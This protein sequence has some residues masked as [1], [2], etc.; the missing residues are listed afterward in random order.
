MRA[1]FSRLKWKAKSRN[2]FFNLTFDEFRKLCL[3]SGYIEGV[4]RNADCLSLDRIDYQKGY[5]LSNLRVITISE[6]SAKGYIEKKL[7]ALGV[8]MVDVY[9]AVAAHPTLTEEE[10]NDPEICPF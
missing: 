4:G 3:A 7:R 2:I 10:M 5:E 9:E 6:N 1:A 8:A